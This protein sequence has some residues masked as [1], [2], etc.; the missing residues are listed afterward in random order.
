MPLPSPENPRS[1][2]TGIREY[3][4]A[5]P[6]Q[7]LTFNLGTYG[8]ESS[9]PRDPSWSFLALGPPVEPTA[10]LE[11]G[12]ISHAPSTELSPN[13]P[14]PITTMVAHYPTIKS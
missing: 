1:F 2:C 5:L 11:S 3:D 13:S 14:S 6:W 10:F 8:H 9:F 4:S 7:S 12:A